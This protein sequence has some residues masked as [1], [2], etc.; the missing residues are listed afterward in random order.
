MNLY[1]Y[2]EML[3]AVCDRAVTLFT[4]RRVGAPSKAVL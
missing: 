3:I 2:T 1:A 4:T